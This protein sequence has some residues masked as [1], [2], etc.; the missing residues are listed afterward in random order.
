MAS[1]WANVAK[2]KASVTAPAP[3]AAPVASAAPGPAS[4]PT[5]TPQLSKLDRCQAVVGFRVELKVKLG[6]TEVTTLRGIVYA[7]HDQMLVLQETSGLRLLNI[8]SLAG[9]P[10]KITGPGAT[11]GEAKKIISELEVIAEFDE[12]QT[13][14]T[15][16]KIEEAKNKR[17]RMLD[18][19]NKNA[20][21]L[22]QRI[23]DHFQKMY[24]CQWEANTIVIQDFRNLRIREP[25]TPELV[26]GDQERAV[27]HIRSMIV[28]LKAEGVPSSP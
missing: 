4:A 10:K 17:K 27:D 26:S 6:G 1:T 11:E 25:Y 18:N 15:K 7:A 2:K 9:A 3:A 14:A 13:A 28:R 24:N 12:A 19:R 20:T 22:G 23:F 8:Q 21:A 5:K 16:E